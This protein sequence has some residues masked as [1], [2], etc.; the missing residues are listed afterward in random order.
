MMSTE[1]IFLISKLKY[2]FL[3]YV[4]IRFSMQYSSIE[5]LCCY[6]YAYTWIAGYRHLQLLSAGPTNSC[7]STLKVTASRK[8]I[9]TIPRGTLLYNMCL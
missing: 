8:I 1:N 4:S 7:H 5:I 2:V 3:F 6:N 9:E